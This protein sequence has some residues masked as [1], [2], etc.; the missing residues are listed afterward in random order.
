M[1]DFVH[2]SHFLLQ[3]NLESVFLHFFLYIWHLNIIIEYIYTYNLYLIPN[4]KF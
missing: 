1:S 3:K 2:F 4:N